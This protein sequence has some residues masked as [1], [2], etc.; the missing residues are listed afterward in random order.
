MY[1]V[2]VLGELLV[3][4]TPCGISENQNPIFERNPGGGPANLACAV[5]RL[6]GKAAFLGKVGDDPFGRALRSVMAQ[7]GVDIR[8]LLLSKTHPTT[9]A[10]V[11]LDAA[12]DRS[13]SFYRHNGADTMLE[14]SELDT[15]V[16]DRTGY[17]FFSSILMAEGTSRETSFQLLRCAK[18][19]KA[20]TVF[21]PNL[22]P[23][24]WTNLGEARN[25]IEKAMTDADIIKLSEEEL[26]FLTGQRDP[27]QGAD[28]VMERFAPKALLV[29]LGA[30]GCFART[31]K[32]RASCG[33]LRVHTI[34]TTAAGDS[35]MGGFLAAAAKLK[36]EVEAFTQKEL[37][38]CLAFANTTGALTTTR[39]GGIPALPTLAEVT[40]ALHL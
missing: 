23:S 9:L 14:F 38:D 31:R 21:D 5:S 29:T 32:A 19:K 4:F 6:G 40:K 10:F 35:F 34:D 11:H 28:Q 39:R 30:K 1:D 27:A 2:V 18:E 15:G 36:K 22:R 17:F 20:T 24:L 33:G 13:F 25:C 37:Q 16:L 3:D 26:D 8:Q 12:G 7:N